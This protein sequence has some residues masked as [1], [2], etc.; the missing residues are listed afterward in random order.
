MR[1][2]VALPMLLIVAL[3]VVLGG[4]AQAAPQAG[5]VHFTAAGD[6]AS[7]PDTG[8]VLDTIKASGSDLTLALGDMS[9]ATVG[10]EQLW[11]DYVTQHVGAGYP[12]ELISGNHE[13]DGINGNINDFSACLP[14][15]LPG[16]IGTYGRQWY[17]DVPAV[18]PLVRFVMISPGLPTRM[19][20][21]ATTPGRRDTSGHHRPSTGPGQ[22]VSRGW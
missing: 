14:N 3:L 21:G 18:N 7:T 10:Q 16:A 9:Y 2:H 19:V 8:A 6:F 20:R 11:C 13:S 12:F 4:G 5:T 15:Q 1:R 17:V 22:L